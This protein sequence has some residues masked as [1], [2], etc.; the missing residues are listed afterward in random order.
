MFCQSRSLIA[1]NHWGAIA[2]PL[3]CR[4]WTCDNCRDN[5]R[6]ELLARCFQGT[7]NRFITITCRRGQFPTENLAAAALA[8]AWRAVVAKWRKLN[9]GKESEY[10]CVLEAHKSGWPH[11]HILWRGAWVTWS[12]LRSE[13][14]TRL[15]SPSVD[16]RSLSSSKRYAAYVAAYVGKASHKFGT[17]KRYWQT[18]HYT[19]LLP[20]AAPR[21]FPDG[22]IPEIVAETISAIKTDW[23]RHGRTIQEVGTNAIRWGAYELEKTLNLAPEPWRRRRSDKILARTKERR[24]RNQE[25]TANEA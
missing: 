20:T 3:C 13:M 23:I 5:R 7:P 25:E 12:W 15:N 10:L 24:L 19:I 21:V 11:L 18:K 2:K 8:S 22:C 14:Q 16:I 9:P 6:R 17:C 1:S 4:S